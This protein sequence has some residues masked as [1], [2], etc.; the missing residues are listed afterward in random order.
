MK[1]F[2]ACAWLYQAAELEVERL[3]KERKRLQAQSETSRRAEDSAEATLRQV[4]ARTR[5]DTHYLVPPTPIC[6][7]L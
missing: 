2:A 1:T 3:E 7:P 4:V 5:T 6:L